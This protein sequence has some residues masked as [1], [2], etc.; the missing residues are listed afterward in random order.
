[1]NAYRETLR[2]VRSVAAQNTKR[3]LEWISWH[4]SRHSLQHC[5]TARMRSDIGTMAH[6]EAFHWQWLLRNTAGGLNAGPGKAWLKEAKKRLTPIGE[7]DFLQKLDAWFAFPPGQA[8]RLSPAGSCA[9]RLL[10]WYGSMV[11]AERS[12]PVLVRIAHAEWQK[13]EPAQKIVSALAWLLR[14]RGDQRYENAIKTIGRD[15]ANDSSEAAKLQQTFDPQEAVKRE[16]EDRQQI[17]NLQR[18][19][20]DAMQELLLRMTDTLAGLVKKQ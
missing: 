20:G 19:T 1:V 10:V 8:V 18:Q 17:Q 16:A 9:L 14:T 2:S 6:K 7:E 4:D 5:W 12:L 11:D 15:W 3:K 13:R